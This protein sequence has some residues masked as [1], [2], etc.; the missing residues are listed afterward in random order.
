MPSYSGVYT[1]WPSFYDSFKRLVHENHSISAIEKFIY[2]KEALPL[3]YNRDIRDVPITE[4]NY[5]ETWN[6]LVERNNKKRVLFTHFMNLLSSQSVISKESASASKTLVHTSRA[7][8]NAL[9]T[10][11]VGI[12]ACD[13]VIVH[14]K[15][16]QANASAMGAGVREVNRYSKIQA[17]H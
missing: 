9:K 4:A 1:D 10:L 16:A 17:I 14:S 3:D 13:E 11:E 7:C 2:L 8:V 12:D 15:T 5:K 6:T